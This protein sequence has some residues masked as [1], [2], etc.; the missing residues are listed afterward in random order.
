MG[1]RVPW[2]VAF[3]QPVRKMPDRHDDRTPSVEPYPAGVRGVPGQVPGTA[4]FPVGDGRWHGGASPQPLQ[5]GIVFLSLEG[6]S[7]EAYEGIRSR[8]G[9][10]LEGAAW[11][12]LLGLLELVEVRPEECF[13]TGYFMGLR[14][15][16]HSRGLFPGA[17]DAGFTERCGRLLMH[18]LSVLRPRAVFTL[19]S[20]VP[21]IL[22]CWSPELA[23]WTGVRGITRLD[24]QSSPLVLRARFPKAGHTTNVAALTHP[25]RHRSDVHRRK[26][27][28]TVGHSAEVLMM[29]DALSAE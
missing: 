17:S 3:R 26:Y 16:G 22:G 29:L 7:M 19:G 25:L 15:E 12:N 21:G 10:N 6:A 18:R 2:A 27:R 13:F 9:E 23:G 11:R 20:Y 5:G 24:A 28:N 14:M 4:F 1:M 8:G